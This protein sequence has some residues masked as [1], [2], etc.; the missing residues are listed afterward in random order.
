MK[1]TLLLLITGLQALHAID[2]SWTGVAGTGF[3]D[4]ANWSALPADTLTDDLAIF[5]PGI[6]A[7]LPQLTASRSL[8]GL[9][10]TNPAGGWNLGGAHVLTLGNGG[11]SS[12][13]QTSGVN[14]ISAGLAL[15][16]A[17]NWQAGNSGTL[18]LTGGLSQTGGFVLTLGNATQNGTVIW[19]P[20]P[21]KSV[22]LTGPAG[23]G[24]NLLKIANGGNLVLGEAG[25]NATASVNE[26]RST[27]GPSLSLVSGGSLRVNSGTW[28]L[29]DIGRNSSGDAFN[30]SLHVA[31]GTLNISG[32][33]YL[34]GGTITVEGGTLNFTNTGSNLSN[35]GR[36][37]LGNFNIGTTATLNVSDGTVDLAQAN[38]GNVIGPVIS[39]RVRQTGGIVRNG[40]TAGG[41]TNGGATTS[42]T[43]GHG[44][45]NSAGSGATLTYTAIS[46]SASAYTLE[47]GSLLCAGVIQG[48]APASPGTNGASATPPGA[49][50]EPGAGNIRNF[51]FLGG[52]LAAAGV[53]ATL[54]GSSS[55]HSNPVANSVSIGTFVNR[56][57]TLAP[58]GSGTA[59]K[60]TIT[61]NF[62][63]AAGVLAIDLGGLAPATSFQSG[64][65]DL[66]EISGTTEL[67]GNL[68]IQLLPGHTPAAGDSFTILTSGGPLTGAF[69]NVPFGNRVASVDGHSSFVV[70]QV[71]NAVTLG[72][73]L[74]VV[75]P[76]ITDSTAPSTVVVGDA[77]VFAVTTTS[78]VP[79]T[80][81]WRKNNVII[82]GAT[83]S[84]LTLLNVNAD[85]SA[86]YEVTAINAEGSPTRSF[87]LIVK[88]L[89]ATGSIVID[90]G[91]SETFTASPIATSQ[92][93]ILDGDVV[94]SAPTFVYQATR[95]A[96]GTHW[97]RVVETYADN[98]TATRQWAVRVR[99]PTPVN[100]LSFYVSPAGSD[101]AAGS[102]GAPFATLEKA[103]DTIRLLNSGQRAGGVTVFLRGGIHRRTTTFALA[104]QDSGTAA[105]PIFY[106]AY[107]GETPVLT[108]TRVLNSAQFSP[109]AAS[110]HA[111]VAPGVDV[112]RI[113]ETD[114][115]G[116]AR[117]ATFPS[118][119]NEWIIFN[120]QRSSLN[121]GMLELFYQGERRLISRYPNHDAAND[122]LTPRLEMNG[123]ATGTATDGTGYLN[124]A[125]TYTLSGGGTAAVGGAFHYDEAD[126]S[127]IDRWQTALTKGGLWVMGYWRVPWQLNAARVGLIDPG[128][129]AIG[130]AT[131]SNPNNALVSNGIGDK[132]N[133]P[134][135]SKK[136]PW[137][138]INLLEE[139]DQ[140]GE[141]C[142][143]FSRQRLY[144]LMDRAGA[145]ADGEIELAD[146][147]TPLV[148][149][150][151]ASDVRLQGLHFRRHLGLNVQI[152]NGERN[153]VLD[154]DFSQSGNFAIDISGGTGHGVVSSNFEKMASGGVMLRGG[155]NS[156]AIVA[157]EHFAVN[158]RFRSF[159]EAV[160]VYQAA[161]DVGY[162]GP[163]GGN[164]PGVG[165]RVA[166]N[167]IRTSPHAGILWNGYQNTIE[168]NELSDFTRVSNDL[169]GIYR[170]GPNIDSGTVIRY[171]HLHASPQ[172]EGI[173]ND[174]DHVRTPIYGN[175]INLKTPSTS[176]RG[177]GIWTNTN[178]AAG[179]AVPGLPMSLRV[180]NNVAVNSRSNYALH[181]TT[182]GLIENNLSYRKIASDFLWTRVTTDTGTNTN[183]IATSNAATLQ[184]GPNPSYGVD[185][186][187]I[188]FANDDLRLRPDAQAYT[189]M[190]G[191]VPIPLEMAGLHADESRA[192]ARVWT[193]FIV[194]DAATAVGANTASLTGTLAYPQFDANATV[195]V[196]WGT[197]DG[198]TDPGAWQNSAVLGQRRSGQIVHTPTDLAPATL[199][200]FRFHA[201]NPA[202]SH[203]AERSN[204]TTTL[205]LSLAPG[206]GTVTASSSATSPTL[207][208]DNDPATSWQT[209]TGNPVGSLIYQFDG[210]AAFRITGY[211]LV[212][213]AGFPARDPRDWQLFGS[214][215]GGT[216]V[217]LDSRVN[218]TFSSRGQTL[219]FGFVNN[220]AFRFHR[221][222]ITANSG[223]PDTLQLAEL[224][225]YGPDFTPDTTGPVITTPGELTASGSTSGGANVTFEVS[226]VDAVSGNAIAT[227]SPASGSLFPIGATLVTVT[228]SD[229][230]GNSSTATFT[231]TV[232]A[233]VLAAPWSIQQIQ[234]FAG[235]HGGSIT[236]PAA[237]SFQ[238]TGT[239]GNTTGGTTGDMWTGNNDSFTYVSQPWS[240]DGI[241][242]A[243]LASFTSTDSSAKAGIV[244]R[245][246][247]NTGSRYSAIYLLRKGDAWAQ[248]KTATSGGSNNVNFFSASS[249]GRGTP[250]WIRLVRQ[251]DIFTCYHSENGT[252]WT[253][254]GSSRS[255]LLGG[256]ELSVGFAVAPRTG[257]TSGT[258]VFDNISFLTP[259]QAWRQTNFGSTSESGNAANNADPDSDGYDNLLE[260]ALAS[261]PTTAASV[262]SIT[263]ALVLTEPDP[264]EHLEI[265]FNRIAD[266]ILLYAVEATDHLSEPWTT[267]W[268]S[269]GAANTAGPVTVSD[270]TDPDSLKPRRFIRLRVTAP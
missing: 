9:R 122:I 89:P 116:N 8:N 86:S 60:T 34:G 41:G 101:F 261:T 118:V 129:K 197:T 128:K 102:I 56:G 265:T 83:S 187:F 207:A 251:G 85:D 240:G 230:A 253:A 180:F 242:T 203:W 267:I 144:F 183:S 45:L 250:E 172:G 156:P 113:W 219:S 270:A 231:I 149:L 264:A 148:Q 241:F 32:G 152:L 188:D 123:V 50:I 19:N 204:S 142:V 211:S 54:L 213:S 87:N 29:G 67:A 115:T 49:V 131:A 73:Y 259:Q 15:G 262:P 130:L 208:F 30:G 266:P 220:T 182:G 82:P 74:P 136:E 164:H 238:I 263:T 95:R 88:S 99:I 92:S 104:S 112:T 36:F 139:L 185:P 52:T 212:S 58:G 234:P 42:L 98:S 75:A 269:T 134:L 27:N 5:G 249:T 191:F 70:S 141:W 44:G 186:G 160:R 194:T 25:T 11:I 63:F 166:H 94:G 153:L 48:A 196:Y 61:G 51:N 23:T 47:G 53:N 163:I 233:P 258:A 143:D 201:E 254:L 150:N 252:T 223:D 114:V 79:V 33:R 91:N 192:D 2:R 184:S 174:F 137:W 173:Y 97:L 17:Q 107:P 1:P 155:A 24:T 260:Y 110:E 111:R 72:Q 132:Y 120:A 125:G 221:L 127:R 133:R 55:T 170:F 40:I 175:T 229:T 64:Q 145:P 167:D 28:N 181:S 222:E 218:Q 171:N 108:S 159:G 59:G 228:A 243:R 106:A 168:Y 3:E 81:E 158:N 237:N 154:C 121:S 18:R 119:F 227:A 146:V 69:A 103:R 138:V 190:P 179:G 169:G 66:L 165:I 39:A 22:S 257:N 4:P 235:V 14:H 246:T 226:A 78:L 20:A 135:G 206:G 90:A 16:A 117:A 124:G 6:T 255:N 236:I 268:T 76:V 147:G 256:S 71:G 245:E 62:Q 109:L 140:P 199:Y 151:G 12:A 217:L 239:G 200:H 68:S 244:F 43:I 248:H 176:S 100:G 177:Y 198:G 46:N 80:Y 178:T 157:A 216:W 31:D 193:P 225:L 93:W 126:A 162:G 7:N 247:T 65:H 215:D 77:V 232:T 37:A 161:V 105:A 189:D 38:S 96:V 205:P 202:G 224:K 10:F 13:G 26:I 84:S 214:Y 209:A 210:S 57:G 21:G 195:R 35:G